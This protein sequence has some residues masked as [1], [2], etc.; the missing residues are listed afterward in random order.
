[1]YYILSYTIT[2][3]YLSGMDLSIHDSKEVPQQLEKNG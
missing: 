1:M 2:Q 3:D